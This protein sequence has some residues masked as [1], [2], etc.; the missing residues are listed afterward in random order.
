MATEPS[1]TERLTAD[2]LAKLAD[3]KVWPTREPLAREA[4]E[5]LGHAAEN[6]RAQ[7]AKA[8]QTARDYHESVASIAQEALDVEKEGGEPSDYVHESVD[9]SHYVIYTHANLTVLRESDNDS[10]AFDDM[11]KDAFAS[12]ESFAAVTQV[13]AYWAMRA[14][15]EQKL[16]E[17]R[18]A[19]EETED[20][21]A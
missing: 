14:D 5:R 6:E 15:I 1:Y 8:A 2:A 10:A 21:E 16:Q 13:L 19:A 3:L 17:L 12:C 9:G 18:D 7:N 11:G 4:I 20:A